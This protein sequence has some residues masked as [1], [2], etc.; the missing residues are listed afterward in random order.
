MKVLVVSNCLL[1]FWVC[2]CKSLLSF[3]GCY[4]VFGWIFD[5]LRLL[6][7]YLYWGGN[8]VDKG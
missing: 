8:G 7:L 3:Y 6:L 5:V 1:C 2:R 4:L